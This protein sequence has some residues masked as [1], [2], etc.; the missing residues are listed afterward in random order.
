MIALPK[1]G[2]SMSILPKNIATLNIVDS[3]SSEVDKM[4]ADDTKL[5][6]VQ[7]GEEYELKEAQRQDQ[8][9]Q[10]CELTWLRWSRRGKLIEA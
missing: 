9:P 4:L 7:R 3:L 2:I 5:S 10:R 8:M 1:R 6:D